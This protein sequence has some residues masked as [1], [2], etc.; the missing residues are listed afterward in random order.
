[1]D[2]SKTISFWKAVNFAGTA[3]MVNVLFLICCI[4]VVTI[5]PASCALY[6][7]IRY[8]I[9][10]RGWFAGFKEGFK[11][12]FLRSAI[13]GVIFV[14]MIGDMA[15]NFNTALNFYL[16]GNS[17][18][19]LII[20]SVGLIPLVMVFSILWPLNVYLPY[21]LT[22]WLKNSLRLLVKAPIQL[23][24]VGILMIAP[25]ALVLYAADLAFMMLIIFLAIYFSLSGFIAT[26]VLKNTL[27]DRVGAY[28]AEHPEETQ[29]T[30]E[31]EEEETQEEEN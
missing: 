21:D 11:K 25:I 13:V 9:G 29:E 7:A 28:K 18:V 27:V 31:E 14:I 23:L 22:E 16:D 24:V 17:Y 4:P 2:Q 26:L 20:Y 19:P 3:I 15:V 5:G 1:M 12:N 8:M 10:G 6:S 30:A